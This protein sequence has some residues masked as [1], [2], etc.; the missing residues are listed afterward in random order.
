MA[1]PRPVTRCRGTPGGSVSFRDK[2][3]KCQTDAYQK[4]YQT[5]EIRS[6]SAATCCTWM[7]RRRASET[8]WLVWLW[9]I[10]RVSAAGWGGYGGSP[11]AESLHTVQAPRTAPPQDPEG[12]VQGSVEGKW[13]W[14][15]IRVKSSHRGRS[16]GSNAIDG[17][18]DHATMGSAGNFLANL[19]SAEVRGGNDGLDLG[20]DTQRQA[21]ACPAR[22]TFLDL[23]QSAL[24]S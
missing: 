21:T 10:N 4:L 1:S 17:L 20:D 14:M 3:C 22:S 5:A 2:W 9:C 19:P 8:F 15:K 24:G 23:S 7:T 13:G 18:P 16:G 11:A 12:Q 6:R